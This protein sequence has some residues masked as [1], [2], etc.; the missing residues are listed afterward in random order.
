MDFSKKKIIVC[1][2]VIIVLNV[3]EKT[4]FALFVKEIIGLQLLIYVGVWM[5]SLIWGLMKTV[6]S[7]VIKKNLN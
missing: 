1:S 5:D 4:F 7:V 3:L 2:V 6:L